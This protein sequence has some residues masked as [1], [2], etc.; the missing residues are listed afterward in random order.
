MS[1]PMKICSIKKSAMEDARHQRNRRRYTV[2]LLGCLMVL[3]TALAFMVPA[4]S[5]TIDVAQQSEGI[6]LMSDESGAGESSDSGEGRDAVES[7][8]SDLDGDVSDREG[9][10]ADGEDGDAVP[11]NDSTD[12]DESASAVSEDDSGDTADSDD[13]QDAGNSSDIEGD[14]SSGSSALGDE[15]AGEDASEDASESSNDASSAD[16]SEPS[17]TNSNA[18]AAETEMPAQTFKN[19]LKNKRGETTF[20]VLVDAPEGA[21]PAGSKMEVKE[22]KAAEVI[23]AVDEAAHNE[24]AREVSQIKAV[25]ITFKNANDEE[26]EPA[27]DV[28]VTMS[29]DLVESDANV[30]VMHVDDEGKADVVKPLTEK[31]LKKRELE[32]ADD[33][34]VFDAAKFS[35]YLVAGIIIEDG[36]L[37]SDGN[38]YTITVTYGEDAGV[39]EGAK[40]EVHEITSQFSDYGDYLS[41]TEAAL[42]CEEDFV[43]YARFFDIK[44]VDANGDKVEITAPVDVRIELADKE[45]SEKSADNMQVVHFADEA[46]SGE[47]VDGVDVIDGA[48]CAVSFEA[49]GFSVYGIVT[50]DTTTDASQVFGIV[51][52]ENAISG[53]AMMTGATNNNKSLKGL[54]TTVRANPTDRSQNVFVAKN[55]NITMWTLNR[56]AGTTSQ[57]YITTEVNNAVKYLR[58]D[59]S[60]IKLV[61]HDDSEWG[62]ACKITVTEGTGAN[63]GKYKFTTNYESESGT[64]SRAL[65]LSGSNFTSVAGNTSSASVWMNFAEKSENLTDDDFVTYKAR[66]ISVSATDLYTP[67]DEA[68]DVPESYNPVVVYTRIW[69][70]DIKRYEYF[71][72]DC[73]GKLIKCYENGDEISWVGSR[74]SAPMLWKVKD[75]GGAYYSLQNVYSDE[76]IVPHLADE[77]S[78]GTYLV[79]ADE[80]ASDNDLSVNLNGRYNGEYYT[81]ILAW[82]DSSYKYAALVADTE[83]YELDTMPSSKAY[84]FYFAMIDERD[85]TPEP[86][87]T[88][89]ETIDHKDPFKIEVKMQNYR[90]GQ[91]EGGEWVGRYIDGKYRSKEQVDVL[92]I[93]T[94]ISGSK[95]VSNMLTKYLADNGYPDINSAVTKTGDHSLYELYDEA[96]E[97]N[98]LFLKSTYDETGYFE[99][100]STKNFAHLNEDGTFTVYD[101]LGTADYG[102]SSKNT[103]KHG[104]FLPYNVL[105]DDWGANSYSRYN[106]TNETDL[107]G[108]SLSTLDP[109][110]GEPLYRIPAPLPGANGLPKEGDADY[111]FG[112][113]MTARFMQSADGLDAWGHD[114]IFEFS[115][116]DD[117]WLYVDG[118]LV[119]D[120]GGVHSAV[121]GSINF[122]T[123]EVDVN[124]RKTN[125]RALFAEGYKASYEAEHPDA[126]PEAVNNAVAEYLSEKFKGESPVLKDY[127]G[128]Y[129]K[130]FYMERGASASN[131]HMRFN[132]APYT[133]GEVLLKKKVTGAKNVNAKFPFQIFIYDENL[134]ETQTDPS[135]RW[136]TVNSDDI[137]NSDPSK[138]ISVKYLEP[139][140]DDSSGGTI[141]GDVEFA[142]E[143]EGKENVFFLK[144]EETASILLPSEGVRYYIKECLVDTNTYDAVYATGSNDPLPPTTD[145]QDSQIITKDFAI[146]D[147][148]VANRK[149]VVYTNHV[150]PDALHSLTITKK[151]WEEEAKEHEISDDDGLFEFRIFLG[152]QEATHDGQP[153][154]VYTPYGNSPYYVKNSAGEYCYYKKNVGFESTGKTELSELSAEIEEGQIESELD[155]ATFETGPGGSVSKIPVGFYVEIPGIVEGTEFYVFERS[156]DMPDGYKVIDYDLYDSA[157]SGEPNK[158][159]QADPYAQPTDAKYM[160]EN[161][162][163]PENCHGEIGGENNP[164]N[165]VVVVNNQHGWHL[166]LKKVWSDAEF[167]KSHDPV[168][169]AVYK[170]AQGQGSVLIEDSVRGLLSPGA[171]LSWFFDELDSG[172]TLNDYKVYEVILSP[173]DADGFTVDVNTGAVSGFYTISKKLEDNDTLDV[174]GQPKENTASIA[175][176]YTVAYSREIL[177]SPDVENVRTDT[178][179]NSR[180]GIKIVKT[181]L[182]DNALEGATF[183]LT[184]NQDQPAGTGRY[185][186][187]SDGLVVMAYLLAGNTYTLTETAPPFGYEALLSEPI[188]IREEVDT[189]GNHTLYVNGSVNGVDGVY[190]VAQ[191]SEPTLENMPEIRIK[192]K[193]RQLKMIKVDSTNPNQV[194]PLAGATFALYKAIQ[195]S[196]NPAVLIPD[197]T[198]MSGFEELVTDD[199]GVIPKV[200]LEHLRA[201]TYFLREVDA[202]EGY[203]KLSGTVCSF[204]LDEMGQVSISTTMPGVTYDY[205]EIDNVLVSTVSIPNTPKKSL[206]VLKTLMGTNEVLSGAEFE[207]YKVSQIGDDGKPLPNQ[208][209]VDSGTTDE[210]GIW[211]MSV[212][213]D[214][215]TNYYLFE[216]KAPEGCIL[217][218]DP[219]II[220]VTSA[221]ATSGG[222][223]ATYQGT[224]M[225]VSQVDNTQVVRIKVPNSNGYE[226]P[227]TGGPGILPLTVI[228]IILMLLGGIWLALSRRQ[229]S[230]R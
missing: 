130:M 178:V 175:H 161:A 81:T 151:V 2:T 125:L 91:E 102:N 126:S 93:K 144:S 15:D 209:P 223:R 82:D 165:P 110:K 96:Q 227:S 47:V 218:T 143:F 157:V 134:P 69:N 225:E 136:R 149:E 100:D 122:R 84:D 138:R 133:D 198:P 56:I 219:V 28:T 173:A 208:T 51:N 226:L 170:E 72:I 29:C 43:S 27:K 118:N 87:L 204:T 34:L 109:R 119:L 159:F 86:H 156:E 97:V 117:F 214:E 26:V 10:D 48:A 172:M 145:T 111:F 71:A 160:F 137:T 215:V 74:N 132:L 197:Y 79:S 1:K 31:E 181:D 70:D 9:T 229:G 59:E 189:D 101:Q 63:A 139:S 83:A 155:T 179:T 120:L 6:V 65:A 230:R 180:S 49:S 37:A 187:N 19:E 54:A 77:G 75:K 124:G 21:L 73:D 212:N 22:V 4:N 200:D 191:V 121:D 24:G 127:S 32:P 35:I 14:E 168:Y 152:T 16:E 114:L 164:S 57:Y 176:T 131:L 60:G 8:S 40:L 98:H 185:T 221:S 46:E 147:S 116:D 202:P 52:S 44:I 55:S 89:V 62:T 11:D 61:D 42:G 90:Y 183:T 85:D 107:K 38:N 67:A 148:T 196:T 146:E 129:M 104:Q 158:T 53:T 190:E 220:T 66:K 58:I 162:E 5:L 88:S 216:T 17:T 23:D 36:V 228:G 163:D 3:V 203:M 206:Q 224:P 211:N 184:D 140:D 45:G 128:H 7:E 80:V 115:G 76:Y 105:H 174:Y 222:I 169:F 210:N 95:V 150:N 194:K 207:L 188:T 103:L 18:S 112:M 106:P 177:E 135:N 64:V 94:E 20:R 25:D 78:A 171:E 192:N 99:Y 92:G 205:N 30:L 142:E 182:N 113:E 108:N 141:G 50:L 39:P 13:G 12:Y 153:V 213:L 199:D 193:Q 33:E 167:M 201:G 166:K 217:L 68:N 123:G 195:D 186:S 154:T 41:K